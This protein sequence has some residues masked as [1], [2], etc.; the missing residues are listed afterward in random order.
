MAGVAQRELA[1]AGGGGRLYVDTDSIEEAG[2]R[3]T[4]LGEENLSI[5]ARLAPLAAQV[6]ALLGLEATGT[7]ARA[8]GMLTAAAA[9]CGAQGLEL[10]TVGSSAKTAAETYAQAEDVA[11]RWLNELA[12]EVPG[13]FYWL[14]EQSAPDGKIGEKI[15]EYTGDIWLSE[16]TA[17]AL[18]GFGY[19]LDTK[20]NGEG[21]AKIRA[22]KALDKIGIPDSLREG[23]A[24]FAF[25]LSKPW[26]SYRDLADD[27]VRVKK[28]DS[29]DRS[30]RG[31]QARSDLEKQ[32]IDYP[33]TA[34]DYAHN[35]DIVGQLI[36]NNDR[37]HAAAGD[38]IEYGGI[39]FQVSRDEQG[40]ISEARVYVPGT[41]MDKK[42]LPYSGEIASVG[43]NLEEVSHDPTTPI[44]DSTAYIQLLDRGL[45]ELGLENSGVPVYL[46]GFSRGGIVVANAS[47]NTEMRSKYNLQGAYI[48]GAPV[49]D[50]SLPD[51]IPITV[52]RDRGD[53][54][55]KLQGNGR[56]PFQ[57][58]NVEYI[59]TDYFGV[60]ESG[61]AEA[62][63]EDIDFWGSHG[64]AEYVEALK[65]SGGAEGQLSENDPLQ[66]AET[67]LVEGSTWSPSTTNDDIA[68]YTETSMAV[69]GYDLVE[70]VGD[71]LKN[72]LMQALP[73][74]S[75]DFD[76]SDFYT[77]YIAPRI[78]EHPSLRYLSP[79]ATFH[80]YRYYLYAQTARARAE[81]AA[82]FA[83]IP[84]EP[85]Q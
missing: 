49:G 78:E 70:T 81:N 29:A 84:P 32:L 45:R 23:L 22:K 25:D 36:E 34:L 73:D 5:G 2:L 61:R 66:Q 60:T 75:E 79:G 58:D 18:F 44:E 80:G 64:S 53:T 20:F 83:Y 72:P 40:N 11:N 46:A 10:M 3:L 47:S 74:L 15:D 7:G 30:S 54:V 41:D 35:L 85:A 28:I 42:F 17:K 31:A 13:A 68:F 37:E 26:G 9:A 55:P 12:L 67:Y 48:Q 69:A 63:S 65:A 14:A 43:S 4:A 62:A 82:E 8:A 52:V 27:S 51:D 1:I 76:Y 71:R 33:E 38:V 56:E 57:A 77:D 21:F 6:A 16:L 59:D 50:D 24:D 19:Y 39:Y